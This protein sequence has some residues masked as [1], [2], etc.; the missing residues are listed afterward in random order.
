MG[1]SLLKVSE[2]EQASAWSPWVCLLIIISGLFIG[3]IIAVLKSPTAELSLLN[4]GYGL[5]LMTWIFAGISVSIALYSLCWE[6]VATCVWNWNTWCRHTHLICRKRTHQHLIILSHI[7]L[8]S[9]TKLLSR[10]THI[11][12]DDDLETP[13]LMLLPEEVMTQGIPRFEQLLRHLISR[14]LPLLLRRYPSGPLRVIVQT[15]GS[16]KERESQSFQHI[17]TEEHLPWETEIELQNTDSSLKIWNQFMGAAKCPI[18]V[19]AMHYRQSEDAIPEFASVLFLMPPSMLHPDEQKNVLRLFRA[20]PLNT[21]LLAAE[22]GELRDTV[23]IPADKK[24]L[25]WH[26]GLSDAAAQSVNRILHELSVPLYEDIGMGGVIDYDRA[27]ARYGALAGWA[28]IGAAADMAVYGP[29]CQW[30]LQENEDDAW[31][32]V[33]GNVSP[34]IGHEDLIVPPPF[35]GGSI[36]IASLLSGGLYSLIIFYFPS[37]AFSWLGMAILLLSLVLM[38]PGMAFVLRYVIA[39]FQYPLFIRAVKQSEKE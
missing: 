26:S 6:I 15:S 21:R 20:M 32:V 34:A 24:S 11:P 38:L 14:I 7:F 18:L 28:M 30:L 3:L 33:L 27:C 22:F 8:S 2:K 31:A 1:W 36:Q 23:F 39:R 37:I 17:W 19:L 25:V 9:D 16:N 10:I 4:S 29:S 5:S 13:P 35:P 12:E